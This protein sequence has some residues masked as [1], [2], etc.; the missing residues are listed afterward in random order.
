MFAKEYAGIQKYLTVEEWIEEWG[1]VILNRVDSCTCQ[2]CFPEGLKGLLDQEYTCIVSIP[3]VSAGDLM[4]MVKKTED[5]GYRVTIYVY[6]GI[7]T[8]GEV[9]VPLTMTKMDF[10]YDT[11]D[12]VLSLN[13]DYRQFRVITHDDMQQEMDRIHE[14]MG[15][16]KTAE[17]A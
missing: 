10:S 3:D 7:F 5:G 9:M 13:F 15:R 16:T 14:K 17:P 6:A 8:I 1:Q 12:A 2:D 11:L 4:V